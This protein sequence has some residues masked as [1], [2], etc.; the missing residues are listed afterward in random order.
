MYVGIKLVDLI[1]VIVCIFGYIFVV[2][3]VIGLLI[4]VLRCVLNLK[5]VCLRCFVFV[6]WFIVKE[7]LYLVSFKGL[8]IWVRFFV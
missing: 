1:L 2:W 7:N 8:V 6:F 3:F 5:F 4:F